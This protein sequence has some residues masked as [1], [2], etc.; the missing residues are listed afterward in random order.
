MSGTPA[1]TGSVVDIV[2]RMKAVLPGGWFGSSPTPVLDALLT[3]IA[4]GWS[5]IY[6]LTTYVQ[7][8]SRITTATDVNL[9]MISVDFFGP[10]VLPRTFDQSDASYRETIL[11]NLFAPKITRAGI[12]S[13]IQRAFNVTPKIFEPFNTGDTG[14]YGTSGVLAWSG[15]AFNDAGGWGSLSMPAQFFITVPEPNISQ[16]G[17][18]NVA[19][20]S[21]A[22]ASESSYLLVTESDSILTTES[23]SLLASD[24]TPTGV[25]DITTE[26]GLFLTTESGDDITT[27]GVVAVSSGTSVIPMPGGYGIGSIEYVAF[28]QVGSIVDANQIYA[29][30]ASLIA[31]G[32]TAWA[33][34]GE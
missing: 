23:G 20:Y 10:G 3:G 34:V 21:S 5:W 28:D 2:A 30:I 4:W 7:D 13:S 24:A 33:R 14:S 19:G 1:P 32:V 17:I 27:D 11:S 8:Q 15:M 16:L 25:L 18:G 31:G 29:L 22:G 26:S 12:I 9:D 6:G